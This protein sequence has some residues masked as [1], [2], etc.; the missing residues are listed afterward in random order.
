MHPL[1]AIPFLTCL[2]CAHVW[3]PRRSLTPVQCPGCGSPYWNRPRERPAK[4]LPT[5]EV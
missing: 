5:P 4:A 2:R 1:P 3:V